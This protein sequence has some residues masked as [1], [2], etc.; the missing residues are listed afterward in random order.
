MPFLSRVSSDFGIPM[1][2]VSHEPLDLQTLCDDLIALDRGRVL[3]HGP[4]CDVLAQQLGAERVPSSLR[5][6]V[7]SVQKR[8]AG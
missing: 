7:V 1:I 4:P 6:T 2:V 3:A 5:T 8:L